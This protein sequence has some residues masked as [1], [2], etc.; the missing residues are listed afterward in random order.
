MDFA[1]FYPNGRGF[2]QIRQPSSVMQ[3]GLALFLIHDW[4]LAHGLNCSGLAARP[5]RARQSVL[6]GCHDLR[7]GNVSPAVGN[8]SF[9]QG[10]D[11]PGGQVRVKL[12]SYPKQPTVDTFTGTRGTGEQIAKEW[13]KV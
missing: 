4:P 10:D 11:F 7:A 2:T 9:E 1:V 8:P 5:P 6:D 3:N 13:R 12:A